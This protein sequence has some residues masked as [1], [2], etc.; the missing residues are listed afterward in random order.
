MRTK[1]I[2]WVA[3]AACTLGANAAT[4]TGELYGFW[5]DDE[6]ECGI[7][8]FYEAWKDDPTWRCDYVEVDGVKEPA[9]WDNYAF[10]VTIS[11]GETFSAEVVHGTSTAAHIKSVKV[12]SDAEMFNKF[13]RSDAWDE[14]DDPCP[15]TDYQ[16]LKSLWSGGPVSTRA[17]VV[18]EQHNVT[19]G[20]TYSIDLAKWPIV[21]GNPNNPC[22]VWLRT[23]RFYNPA[24]G[25][26]GLSSTW[27]IASY[28]K[29]FGAKLS[30]VRKVTES[31]WYKVG[32][33]GGDMFP[34]RVWNVCDPFVK[35]GNAIDTI[36]DNDG[37]AELFDAP[38]LF[39][40]TSDMVSG[41]SSGGDEGEIPSEWQKARTLKGVARRA[42]PVS[43][44]FQGVFELK[45]GKA[46]KKTKMAKVSAKLTGID[47]K[48][49]SYK[50]KSVDVTGDTVTVDFDG[51]EITIDG[52]TFSG[53]DGLDGGIGVS[54]AEVGGALPDGEHVFSLASF[55]FDVP[56]E[57]QE[58]LLPYEAAFRSAGGKWK[59]AKNASVKWKKD[60]ETKEYGLVVDDSSDKTNL[61]S[62]KLSYAPKTGIFKGSFKAYALE[63]TNGKTKLRKYTVQVMGFVVDGEG[64]GQATCKRPS[65]GP[66][67]VTVE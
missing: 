15:Y 16:T 48:K 38:G 28:A 18:V 26:G 54:S 60:R 27:T 56:G 14:Y 52:D 23:T 17:W 55:D 40:I 21:N 51:L 67:A 24:D 49:K 31:V 46:N 2:A 6:E 43:L 34:L 58:S 57:I 50:A 61:A 9:T 1:M 30:G 35:D 20:P 11:Q 65:G 8:K 10:P 47:G 64:C 63:E 39:F 3:G 5:Y 29:A 42:L 41:G 25:D 13:R 45:C 44:D 62:L 33:K 7:Y 4:F 59:F 66:W 22:C 12:V 53:N 37:D 32:I 19:K 36:D